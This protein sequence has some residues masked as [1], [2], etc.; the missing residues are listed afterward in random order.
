MLKRISN[1][2]YSKS[3]GWAVVVSLAVFAVFIVVVLP[4]QAQKAGM[5]S[6]EAGSPD[7]SFFYTPAD[8]YRM[9]EA[10]GAEGR[11]AYVHARF[12]F[13][14]VW[15]LAYLFFLAASISWILNLI[16]PQES[17]GRLLNLLPLAGAVFDYLEN[18]SAALVMGRYPSQTPVVDM[19]APLFTAAKW[20]FINGSFLLL[21]AGLTIFAVRWARR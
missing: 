18:I 17:R 14:V 20:I 2:I 10:Y 6:G 15:P 9:A 11:A 1:F 19:L 16:L 21:L 3:S 7:T 5:Y 12:T 13:D 8:L 4:D